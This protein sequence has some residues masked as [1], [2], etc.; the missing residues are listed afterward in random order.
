MPIPDLVDGR[1]PPGLHQST[2]EEVIARFCVGSARRMALK[3]PL[4]ELIAVAREARAIGLY[5]NGSFVTDK[6]G[7][8]DIDA[9]IV[10]CQDFNRAGP[11]ASRL[12]R[13]HKV[14]GFDIEQVGAHDTEERDYLLNE[15]FGTDRE[16]KRRGLVE[17]IL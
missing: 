5:L 14:Y 16:G 7:P 4:Q 2:P 11:L 9:V 6:E 17:V 3:V 12:L 8:R 1:L 15:F 10:H 13:L